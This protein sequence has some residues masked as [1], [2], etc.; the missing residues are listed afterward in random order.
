MEKRILQS[1]DGM[2]KAIAIM[3]KGNSHNE[4][5][6]ATTPQMTEI[7]SALARAFRDLETAALK[8]VPRGRDSGWSAWN[9]Q[10]GH[11]WP[12]LRKALDAIEEARP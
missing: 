8:Y 1:S 3:D 11:G 2:G 6:A 10:D 7:P 5:T 12:E 4:F 9:N